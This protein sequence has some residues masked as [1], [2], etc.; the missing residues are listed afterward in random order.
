MSQMSKK[1]LNHL[2]RKG[3]VELDMKTNRLVPSTR[4]KEISRR[5]WYKC[6]QELLPIEYVSWKLSNR[7]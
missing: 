7:P 4:G 3:L 2:I 5:E 1:M 6:S